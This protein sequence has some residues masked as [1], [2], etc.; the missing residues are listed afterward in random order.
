MWTLFIIL[1]IIVA[2]LCVFAA[3]RLFREGDRPVNIVSPE[4]LDADDTKS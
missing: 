3:V 2:I 1:G 4:E